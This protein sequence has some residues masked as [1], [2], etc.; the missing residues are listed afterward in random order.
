[1]VYHNHKMDYKIFKS[2]KKGQLGFNIVKT[3]MIW[4]LILSIL[5]IVIVL[6]LVNLRNVAEE[7]DTVTKTMSE[8]LTTV[9]EA[10]E[11]LTP[12]SYRH[13]TCSIT[14]VVNS[15]DSYPINSA[16]YTLSSTGCTV[17]FATGGSI[18]FNNTNWEVNYST[19][20]SNPES[21]LITSN[22][23]SSLTND[24]FDQT[25]TIFAILIVVVII[26]AISII[27]GVVTRFHGG[28][29]GGGVSAGGGSNF[30]NDTV[31]GI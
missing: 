7:I 16:N 12:E 23:T 10:G 1:M 30:G 5:A 21:Y 18:S 3:V 29:E 13:P 27:I 11:S 4:F 25:G 26:L 9:T 15:T 17:T 24:F 20:Y 28:G 6:A 19:T 2:N 31:M 8:T 22:V 14:S